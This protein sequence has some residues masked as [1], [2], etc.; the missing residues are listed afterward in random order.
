[1]VAVNG[2]PVRLELMGQEDTFEPAD[3]G[4]NYLK[5]TCYCLF[6]TAL[7]EWLQQTLKSAVLT[8]QCWLW[9]GRVNW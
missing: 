2:A 7:H 4:V 9:N 1:M 8:L 6:S 5:V 3:G